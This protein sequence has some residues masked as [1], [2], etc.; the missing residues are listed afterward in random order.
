[1]PVPLVSFERTAPIGA[2][3]ILVTG[4]TGLLG[5]N[6]ARRMIE[7]GADVRVLSRSASGCRSLAGLDVDIA[8]PPDELPEILGEI[9]A[10]K[11]LR[12]LRIAETEKYA[13]VTFFLNG[14]R[15]EPFEGEQRILVPSPR[16]ATY[17]LQPEMSAPEVGQALDEAIRSGAFDVI[18]CNLANPDM[19]GHTGK[20]DAAVRAAEVVDGLVGEIV[21]ATLA[22]GGRLVVTAD[23][24]N[25]EQM[26]D[27]E[28]EAPHTAHTTYDVE[29]ILQISID[30][31]ARRD[32]EL[33]GF[34]RLCEQF[35]TASVPT[36]CEIAGRVGGGGGE[37]AASCDMRFG[38]LGHTILCQM[39]V[40][41]G[42]LPGGSGTQRLS[43]LVGRG[44]AME[45]VLAGDDIDAE[46]LE[47]W[48]WLNRVVEP[49]ELS[50]FVRR[51]AR[52]MASFPPESI[53]LAKS[54]VLAGIG[55]P[56]HGLLDEAY[57]F[58]QCVRLPETQRRLHA[59]LEQGGQTVEGEQRIGELVAELGIDYD[60]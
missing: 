20:L 54:A 15:E 35:R 26:W 53:G 16:V 38:A 30:E 17:D 14:G 5:N 59:F 7:A 32:S 9:L 3:R 52:R 21:D 27:P 58:Q 37:L 57:L 2:K 60:R 48:G 40:P 45:I 8:Y 49:D 25:S 43:Q 1:M 51:L 28:T 41:L 23:H 34:H 29:L 47:R 22:R 10:R 46:T 36:L 55:D 19:V 33:N 56:T 39:E 12:Q 13:H 18:F 6:V 50:P 31:P 24:G 11:G 44:R 4:A 42:I